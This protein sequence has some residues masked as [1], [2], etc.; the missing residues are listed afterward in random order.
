M[1][2]RHICLLSVLFVLLSTSASATRIPGFSFESLAAP[3][4]QAATTNCSGLFGLTWNDSC[5]VNMLRDP[6]Y[7]GIAATDASDQQLLDYIGK[8]R[9]A[10]LV[11]LFQIDYARAAQRF[12]KAEDELLNTQAQEDFTNSIRNTNDIV[13]RTQQISSIVAT[14]GGSAAVSALSGS[15]DAFAT[16]LKGVQAAQILVRLDVTQEMRGIFDIYFL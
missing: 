3:Q 9:Q 14:L 1:R 12:V 6:S 4:T 16:V 13:D 5:L 8:N 10:V 2:T 15:L 7:F 11:L